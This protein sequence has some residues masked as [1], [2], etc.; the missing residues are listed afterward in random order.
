M[1]SSSSQIER[2]V[3]HGMSHAILGSN[4]MLTN[5]YAFFFLSL[6]VNHVILYYPSCDLP[7]R[8]SLVNSPRFYLAIPNLEAFLLL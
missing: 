3:A 8:W 5:L 2:N 7:W 6:R 1:M 4:E